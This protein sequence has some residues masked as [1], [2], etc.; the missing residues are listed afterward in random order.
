[1]VNVRAR[2]DRRA[3]VGDVNRLADLAQLDE[4][5]R[6]VGRNDEH[7]GV[8][9][10]EDAGLALVGL[11][12]VVAGGDG[13]GHQRFEVRRESAMRAQLRQTPQKSGRPSVSVGCRQLTALASI[14]AS[15]YLP[16]PLG[17]ARMSE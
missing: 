17:P 4:Q 10:D 14:R 15:V 7:V 11:A 13:L 12:Q 16:A 2:L 3:V 1:M 8:G 6:R 5:L 9:L